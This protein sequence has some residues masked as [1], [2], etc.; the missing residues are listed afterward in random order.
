MRSQKLCS[1]NEILPAD[2]RF[3]V[4]KGNSEV[5]L[6]PQRNLSK[7]L[8]RDR[9]LGNREFIRH[10]NHGILAERTGK[11]API[12]TSRKDP[13]AWIEMLQGLLLDRVHRKRSDSSIVH[14]DILAAACPSSPAQAI[15]SFQNQTMMK[16]ARAENFR[17]A[18]PPQSALMPPNHVQGQCLPSGRQLQSADPEYQRPPGPAAAIL[19]DPRKNRSRHTSSR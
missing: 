13:A 12:R 8:W 14:A 19:F 3:I 2:H 18:V 16:T 6:L 10:R 11:I 17:H 9:T 15:L 7:F 5:I 1:V 4:G